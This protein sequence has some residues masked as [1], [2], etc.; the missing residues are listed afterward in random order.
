MTDYTHKMVDGISVALTQQEIQEFVQRDLDFAN[1]PLPVPNIIS[2]RQFFQ[3]LAILGLITQQEALDA[4][5]TGALPAGLGALL[6]NV[7]PD[8]FF[9]AEMLLSG[10]TEFHRD[11]ALTALLGQGFGWTS[12]QLDQLWRDASLL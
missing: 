10:S 2:D 12:S 4:V 1:R 5:K 6:T 7:S 8:N 3:Q 11:H 9:A